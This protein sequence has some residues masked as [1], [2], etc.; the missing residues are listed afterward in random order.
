[1]SDPAGNLMMMADT[2]GGT[3]DSANIIMY[4]EHTRNKRQSTLEN[5]Q[6]G[7]ERK[8]RDNGGEKGDK[9]RQPN[10]NIKKAT[11]NGNTTA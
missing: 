4:Q 10:P 1:M 7:Q 8:K 2:G 6:K 3:I 9:R 11:K 5:H